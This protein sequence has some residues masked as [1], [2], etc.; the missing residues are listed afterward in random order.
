MTNN[1][2]LRLKNTKS[3]IRNLSEEFDKFSVYH[4]LPQKV[5]VDIQLALDEILTNIVSYGY[6]AGAEGFIEVEIR[7]HENTLEVEVVDD[8]LPF[9][10]LLVDDPD[11][12]KPLQEKAIGGLGI[13]LVKNLMDQV[14][15]RRLDA[16][17]HLLLKKVIT[18]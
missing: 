13:Y 5:T 16:K 18:T 14:E 17:N 2:F 9:N 8:A 15:Y 1:L 6:E 11:I 10:I 4:N 12:Q 7:L 3:D